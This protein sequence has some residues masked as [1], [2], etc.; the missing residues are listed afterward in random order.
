M[1]IDMNLLIVLPEFHVRRL[2]P[3]FYVIR[4]YESFTVRPK[5]WIVFSCTAPR[6]NAFCSNL[7]NRRSGWQ[8]SCPLALCF[9]PRLE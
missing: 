2:D 1:E 4:K 6:P 8:T 5:P 7:M 3:S 9:L